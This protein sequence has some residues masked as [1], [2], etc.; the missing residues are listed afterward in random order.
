MYYI[1]FM[2]VGLFQYIIYSINEKINSVTF[3]KFI[4]D[5][6]IFEDLIFTKMLYHKSAHSN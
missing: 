2:F 3:V 5:F 1:F 4:F 6:I